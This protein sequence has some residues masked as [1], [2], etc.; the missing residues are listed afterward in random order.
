MEVKD[1][2]KRIY[3]NEKVNRW[4]M[5]NR[6]GSPISADIRRR[7]LALYCDIM[8]TTPEAILKQAKEK[9]LEENFERFRDL[10]LSKG[11]R[12]A[13]VEKFRQVLRSWTKFN[14]IDYTIN[15]KIKNSNKN[16][17]T[18]D[19]RV[20]MRDELSRFL[21]L[22]GPRGKVSISLMAFSGLRPESLG[23]YEGNDGLI[24]SDMEDLDIRTLTFRKIPAKVNIRSSISKADNRYFTFLN[25]EGCGYVLEYL[26]KRRDSGEIL[27][28]ESPLLQIDLRGAYKIT[29]ELKERKSGH[30]F[31]RTALITRE[32]RDS[33]RSAGMKFRPYVLRAFFATALDRA[34]YNGLISHAWR[35]FFM[36]H[37]GDIE[38]V[39]STNKRLLPEQIEEMRSAYLKASKFLEPAETVTKEDVEDAVKTFTSKF[40]KIM[41]FS[42][43][44]IKEMADL[45]DDELQRRI[46]EKRGMQLN[47]GHKQKVISLG[48]VERFLT[49]GWEYVNSLP[50]DK[51]IVKIPD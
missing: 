44:E 9:S 47:N 41:G 51:A 37:K 21:L 3:E 12:G 28:S 23:N 49:D 31:L 25:E 50:G 14:R 48:E 32:I 22:A 35:Q 4:Y 1:S 7:N 30:T 2:H 15:L 20:P 38:F 40:L 10:M 34:E 29:N 6:Q 13:Y 11:K 42:D 5:N 26:S 46:Q 33:I 24:L 45:S 27:T 43:S 39:Y 8:H 18:E 36:G 19:E 16:E 17:T